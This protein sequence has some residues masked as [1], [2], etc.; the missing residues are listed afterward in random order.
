VTARAR[1]KAALPDP[2]RLFVKQLAVYMAGNQVE[3]SIKLQMGT[4]EAR[5]WAALRETTP[6]FGYPTVHEAEEQLARWLGVP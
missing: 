3:M 6:L 5:A 4:T 2:R 1:K